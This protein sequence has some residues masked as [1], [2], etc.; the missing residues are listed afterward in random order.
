[1][2]LLESKSA[3]SSKKLIEERPIKILFVDLS[4]NATSMLKRTP[5]VLASHPSPTTFVGT[6]DKSICTG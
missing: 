2:S 1:M 6:V 5:D 4:V 3:N